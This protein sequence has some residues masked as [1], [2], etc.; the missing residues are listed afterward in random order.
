ME[1]TWKENYLLGESYNIKQ[2]LEWERTRYLATLIHNVNCQKKIHMKKPEQMMRLP[3]DK[4]KEMI[5]SE[6]K[7]TKEQFLSFWEK[8]KKLEKD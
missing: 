2:N 8:V 7:S 3:Q 6:V 5:R 4:M 1:N